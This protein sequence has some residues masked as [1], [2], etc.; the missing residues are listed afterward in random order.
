MMTGIHN[1]YP[2]LVSVNTKRCLRSSG[3]NCTNCIRVCPM[4]V[5]S[6]RDQLPIAL[7]PEKCIA[8]HCCKGSCPAGLETIRVE[9]LPFQEKS[10]TLELNRCVPALRVQVGGLELDSPILLASGPIGRCA[11]G[12]LQATAFGFGAVITKTVTVEPRSG[13]P[14]IRIFPYAQRSIVNCEGLPNLGINAM[15]QEMQSFKKIY[16]QCVVVPSLSANIK[17]DFLIMAERLEAAGADALELALH[18]CPNVVEGSKAAPG[19]RWIA[20]PLE[21]AKLIEA[22]RGVVK[23]P[24][25][26]KVNDYVDT[27]V[28]CQEAGA[29]AL[30]VRQR[31]AMAMPIDSETGRPVL[32]HPLGQGVF[33]GPHTKPYGLRAVAEIAQRVSLPIIGN[34]GIWSAQDVIDYIRAGAASV[35][36]ITLAIRRGLSTVSQIVDDLEAYRINRQIKGIEE[37]RGHTHKYLTPANSKNCSISGPVGFRDVVDQVD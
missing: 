30:I 5:I 15:V 26:V 28:A 29:D 2:E 35:Q 17:E 4:H 6:L 34:G 37:L 19:R 16:S 18:G 22:V 9:H 31:S 8:C 23:I 14:S 21:T 11:R 1:S 32:S 7:K 13:N 33:T 36:L 3:V 24:I 25:W 12:W 10:Q 27:A 20:E